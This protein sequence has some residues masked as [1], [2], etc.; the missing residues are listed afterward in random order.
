MRARIYYVIIVLVVIALGLGSRTY[1]DF[2]PEYIAVNAGDVLWAAMIYYGIRALQGDRPLKPAIALSVLF[3]F[4]IECSQLYQ[5]PWI[6]AI[7][8]TS[9]GGLILG[10]GFLA[11]DLIRYSVG[12]AAACLIDRSCLIGLHKRM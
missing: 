1:G 11:V 8:S 2:L 3:C 4:A 9:L 10:K 12:I 6:N 7:R 5:S